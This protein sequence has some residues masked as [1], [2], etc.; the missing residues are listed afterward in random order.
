MTLLQDY[1]ARQAETRPEATAVV[2]GG[3]RLSYGGLEALSNRL[4]RALRE[5]GCR[6]GDR[7]GLLVPKSPAAVAGILAV[8]KSGG[9]LVPLDP[10][11]PAARLAKVLRSAE[12]RLVLAGGGAPGAGG[13]R[14]RSDGVVERLAELVAVAPKGWNRLRF[15]WLGAREGFPRPD[16]GL[17]A[18]LAPAFAADDLPRHSPEPLESR[19]NAGDPAHILYTSG[20]TG[21]PKGV[22]VTHE[23][24]VRFVEW[25]VRH[26]RVGAG[27]RLSGHSPLHFDL[28]TFDLFGAFAAGA[29]LHL[30]PPELNLLP[31]RLADF[32]RGS[33]LTQWFSVPSVLAYMAQFEV[34]AQDDFPTLRRLL[35][36]G[37]VF[38]P[39]ALAHWVRRLPHVA[40]TNLYGPTETTIASSFHDLS[41]GAADERE[42]VP[43]GRAC[44]GEE[45]LVLDGDL[46]SVPPG[47]TGELYIAGAGLSPGYWRDPA[48][49]AAAFLPDPRRLRPGGR[50]YR[51]GDLARADRSG[52]VHVLGRADSQI[53]S[54]GYRI[55][56]GEIETAIAALGLTREAV[57]TAVPSAGF[58]GH[59]IC[60]AYVPAGGVEAGPAA[61]RRELGRLLPGYM[62]PA[63]W[64]SWERLPR[65]GSGKLDRR[66]VHEAFAAPVEAEPERP[67]AAAAGG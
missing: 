20:S 65:N 13:G 35:W 4:A 24:V 29:E 55:E 19:G 8:Y 27:E 7:V 15:G 9:I 39:P 32:I 46:R 18:P 38:P 49:T 66:R 47:E 36:C 53:K 2:L 22:M 1:V 12:C 6:R 50:I 48:R 3:E 56:L 59:R 17:D 30:V 31:N 25:A 51:T 41:R 60:C 40:F 14:D 23:S 28:S 52:R 21:E 61:L 43:I 34:V 5:A 44:D 58:E 67:A 16:C 11:S 54:R 37:E 63:R 64:M 42:P 33:R 10:G 62:I 57:V 45:L 26:F